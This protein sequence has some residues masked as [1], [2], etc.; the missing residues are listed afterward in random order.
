[1]AKTLNRNAPFGEICGDPPANLG[2]AR[3]V[4]DGHYFDAQGNEVQTDLDGDGKPDAQ[5]EEAHAKNRGGRPPKAKREEATT[6][7]DEVGRQL[8]QG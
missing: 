5:H 2:Y 6:H 8:S 3:Y 7:E 1:M 4:Q